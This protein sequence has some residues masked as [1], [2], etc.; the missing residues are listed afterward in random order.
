MATQ[1]HPGTAV[2]AMHEAMPQRRRRPA[3]RRILGTVVAL[4]TVIAVFAVILPRIADYGDVWRVM[5]GLST[6]WLAAL[7]VATVINIATYAP[8]WMAA[9]P[10]LGYGQAIVLTQTS[11]A[12]S[13][14]VPGG[15]AVGLAASYAM[16]RSWRYRASAIAVAVVVTAAWNQIVNVTLPM[17]ALVLLLLTGGSSPLLLT[18]GLIGMGVVVALTAALV[19]ALRGDRQAR[20]LGDHAERAVNAVVCLIRRP[21]REGWGEAA[22]RFRH[23]TVGLLSRRWHL[24]TLA[25]FAGHLAVFGVLM[26]SLRA[27]GVDAGQVSWVEAL[28]AWGLIR[29]LTAVPITPGGVGIVE[30][31][32]A[33]ALVGFGAGNANAVAAVL[34]YRVLTVIPTLVLGALFGL[35][36][37]RHRAPDAAT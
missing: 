7:A 11:T 10:G 18:A 34:L 20:W 32:L 25:A 9:L 15:D 19:L 24:I 35:T 27:T 26:V 28:A 6:G 8:P 36:W 1:H 30:L 12:F 33:S 23:E 13:I 17:V 21:R 37:R 29:L 14:A 5:S 3:G 16:L 22:V 2:D 4:V 31:G